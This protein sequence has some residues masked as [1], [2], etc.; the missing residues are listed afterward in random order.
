[1]LVRRQKS[2]ASKHGASKKILPVYYHSVSHE[3]PRDHRD[4]FSRHAENVCSQQLEHTE[5]Q[6]V[7]SSDRKAR[8]SNVLQQSRGTDS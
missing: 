5:Q 2:T 7:N 6:A 8:L 4:V 3:Y 1:M